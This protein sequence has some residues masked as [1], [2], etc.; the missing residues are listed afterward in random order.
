[1]ITA[2]TTLTAL[3]ISADAIVAVRGGAGTLIE[4]AAAYQKIIPVVAVKGTGGIADR[5]VDSYT[6]DRK[7]E[8]IL[9]EIEPEKAVDSV[10]SS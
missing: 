2:R 4:I 9:G 10:C 6:D 7:T 5:F 1:M 8:Q 3:P